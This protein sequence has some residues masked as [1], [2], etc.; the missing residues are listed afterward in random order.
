MMLGLVIR[1]E[2]PGVMEEVRAS[3]DELRGTLDG[4][5]ITIG[6]APHSVHTALPQ[7]YADIAAYAIEAGLPVSTHLAGSRDEY[8]FVKWG[9]SR[10]ATDFRYEDGWADLDWLPT[11]VSPVRYVL[12][13]GLF[14]V[15]EVL[16]VHLIQVDDSDIEVLAEHDIAVA[17]CPRCAAKLGM[18]IAPLQDF[19]AQGLRIGLGTDSPASNN[20]IDFFEEMRVGLLLQRGA[21][22]DWTYS[23]E[24]F[25]RFATL[26]GAEALRIEDRVGSLEPGKE[27]DIIVVDLSHSHQAPILNPYSAIVHTSNQENIVFTMVRGRALCDA[28]SCS[29][30]DMDRA[31]ARAEEMRVKLRA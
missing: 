8:D 11:G 30:V 29:T 16:G 28:G 12:Q 14:A 22:R 21:K 7:L 1:S 4:D 23:A 18:G 6:V 9:S 26:G 19:V 10:L 2:I 13:W 20:T 27:A 24:D 25:V 15:P 31:M 3:V 5:R 17:N